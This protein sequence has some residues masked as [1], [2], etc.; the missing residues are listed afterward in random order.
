MNQQIKDIALR[1]RGLRDVLD[2]EI[3]EIAEVCGLTAEQY[4]LYES[5]STDIPVGMLYTISKHYKI[6]MSALMFGQE[7]HMSSYFLTRK[8]TGAA[9]KRREAY[10]YQSL[11]AGFASRKDNPF[12]VQV[13]PSNNDIATFNAH[14]GH[15]FSMVLEGRML[16]IIDGKELI[17]EEGDSIYFDSERPHLLRALDEKILT[18]LTIII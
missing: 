17:L 13:M 12:L 18:I 11:A 4:E 10:N 8:G 16:I 15:E 2:L 14:E 1:L 9:V 7:A 6:E 5:G 3:G